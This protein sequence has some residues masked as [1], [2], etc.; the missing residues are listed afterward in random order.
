MCVCAVQKKK[1]AEFCCK[2]FICK[3]GV[4]AHEFY[5]VII[6][7]KLMFTQRGRFS[8]PIFE[9]CAC[10]NCVESPGLC[11]STKVNPLHYLSQ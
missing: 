7:M 10:R 11:L 1:K 5:S 2:Q 9:R 6:T 4:S 3:Y 8:K